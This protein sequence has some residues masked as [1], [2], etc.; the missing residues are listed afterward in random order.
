MEQIVRCKYIAISRRINSALGVRRL[1]VSTCRMFFE[2]VSP[3]KTTETSVRAINFYRIKFHHPR[4]IQNLPLPFFISLSFFFFYTKT[5]SIKSDEKEI[6]FP[7]E[8]AIYFLFFFPRSFSEIQREK[9]APF[10]SIMFRGYESDFGKIDSKGGRLFLIP[11]L[12]FSPKYWNIDIYRGCIYSWK[13]EMHETPDFGDF[14]ELRLKFYLSLNVEREIKK[15]K[16]CIYCLFKRRFRIRK[17]NVNTR[18]MSI[19][20]SKGKTNRDGT[21]NRSFRIFFVSK[22]VSMFKAK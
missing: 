2:N 17:Q 4:A 14:D 1:H 7:H 19:V 18:S 21:L 5:S 11:S 15:G 9:F 16:K 22:R 12:V 6:L 13:D 10:S 20:N 3:F 8:I